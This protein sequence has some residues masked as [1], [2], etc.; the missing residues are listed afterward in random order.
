M[1]VIQC[2]QHIADGRE[3]IVEKV[4]FSHGVRYA[5]ATR[6]QRGSRAAAA[7]II[8]VHETS[9]DSSPLRP[10]C[11]AVLTTVPVKKK[12]Q[13]P[14]QPTE[15]LECRAQGVT[16]NRCAYDKTLVRQM[17]EQRSPPAHMQ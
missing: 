15:A 11:R 5:I 1:F 9:R 14:G 4:I 17:A 6:N 13:P 7:M 12:P 16:L 8:A 2:L 10:D 3:A